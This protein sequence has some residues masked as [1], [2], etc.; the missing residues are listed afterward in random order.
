MATIFH[1]RPT[2]YPPSYRGG[3]HL[4][5]KHLHHKQQTVVPMQFFV[6]TWTHKLIV[7]DGG[8]NSFQTNDQSPNY[9]DEFRNKH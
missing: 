7:D 5:C 2:T 3:V 6:W 4:H 1:F 9:H 8:L